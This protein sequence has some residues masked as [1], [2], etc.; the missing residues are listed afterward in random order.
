MS[1]INGLRIRMYV[2]MALVFAIGFGIVYALLLYLGAGMGFIVPLAMMFFIMQWYLSPVLLKMGMKLHYLEKGERPEL[3][4]MVRELAKNAN[5]PM[6]KVA[7]AP[8]NDPNAFVFGRTVKSATLVVHQGLLNMLDKDELRAVLAHEMGHLKHMDIVVMAVVAFIPA[9]AIM[10]AQNLFFSSMFGG[11][12]GQKNSGM[13]LAVIGI[14]AFVV[15]LVS[16]L[17]V[18]SLSRARESYADR[19]SA[20]VTKRPDLLASS[21]MK[22]TAHNRGAQSSP[23]AARAFYIVDFLNVE[24]DIKEIKAHEKEIRKLLPNLDIDSLVEEARQS[25]KSAVNSFASLFSTHPSTYR[26]II[27]LATSNNEEG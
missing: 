16:Q 9:I 2:T 5:V 21:L 19:H 10:I 18:F 14:A 3:Q 12:G 24:K 17:L 13:S 20:A 26:R 23:N 25:K 4:E 7:I 27:D 11:R 8:V 22:I 6:P 15:Y 1:I